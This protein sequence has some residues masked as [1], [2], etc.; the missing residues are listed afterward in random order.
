MFKGTSHVLTDS[1][2]LL[3]T[4]AFLIVPNSV[5]LKSGL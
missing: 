3:L 1:T 4:A 5:Q 2:K